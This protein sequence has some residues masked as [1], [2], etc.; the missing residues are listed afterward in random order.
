M[1]SNDQKKTI[2][3]TGASDG[4]GKAMALRLAKDGHKL[5]LCGRDEERLQEVAKQCS[6]DAQT[7]V[8]DIN[9][10][11]PRNCFRPRYNRYY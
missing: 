6:E 7:F 4:I 9:D 11:K 2:L 1:K 3:I 10:H 8:F 5:L